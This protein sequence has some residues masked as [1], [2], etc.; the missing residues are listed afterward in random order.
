MSWLAW[1]CAAIS[2]CFGESAGCF[3]PAT[4]VTMADGSLREIGNVKIGEWVTSWDEDKQVSVAAKVMNIKRTQRLDLMQVKCANQS[5]IIV[6]TRDH[7][8]W[9]VKQGGLISANPSL[10]QVNY[11]L[12]AK[13]FLDHEL[14]QSID[15]SAVKCEVLS[16][17]NSETLREVLTLQL[18][19]H[20]W[21]FVEGVRVHNKGGGG[22]FVLNT[23][24]TMADESL[25]SIGEVQVGDSVMSWDEIKQVATPAKVLKIKRAKRSD[26][27]KVKLTGTN[28]VITA[29]RDHPFWS[30]KQQSLVSAEPENTKWGYDLDAKKFL[31]SDVLQAANGSAVSCSII[32]QENSNELVD[33]MTLFLEDHHWFFVEG[34]RVHN[35]G[36]GSSC[37]VPS[38]LI[39]MADEKTF[40][41]I[42]D[43]RI[44][45]SVLSWDERKN[46]R[47]VAKVMNVRRGQ[48]SEMLHV[49]LKSGKKIVSTVDHPYWSMKQKS[50]V[51]ADPRAT[52]DKYGLLASRFHV[53]GEILQD[54]NATGVECTASHVTSE[55]LLAVITLE[56]QDHHWFFAEGVRVHNKGGTYSGGT[57]SGSYSTRSSGGFRGTTSGVY[58]STYT[59]FYPIY[60]SRSPY[61]LRYPS[62][63]QCATSDPGDVECGC[64][65]TTNDATNFKLY[66]PKEGLRGGCWLQGQS[67][68]CVPTYPQMSVNDSRYLLATAICKQ[69][70]LDCKNVSDCAD[71]MLVNN[72]SAGVLYWTNFSSFPENSTD[73]F[74]AL[75]QCMTA[76]INFCK[77]EWEV[78]EQGKSA[79][80]YAGV[81]LGS[82]FGFLALCLGSMYVYG[83][84]VKKQREKSHW[85]AKRDPLI[86]SCKH[87]FEAVPCRELA[88]RTGNNAYNEGFICD[89]CKGGFAVNIKPTHCFDCRLDFCDGCLLKLGGGAQE[90]PQYNE[91]RSAACLEN[92]S[93]AASVMETRSADMGPAYSTGYTCDACHGIFPF[94]ATFERCSLCSLDFCPSCSI[95]RVKTEPAPWN[96]SAP[97][98]TEE[99]WPD[100]YKPE[101]VSDAPPQAY[102]EVAPP[103]QSN[104][105]NSL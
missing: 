98:A 102:E 62:Q 51:S 76:N 80:F 39:T 19:E 95:R 32:S 6:S 3:L 12:E 83:K 13:I 7:P 50:L 90:L 33:V 61:C 100:T 94:D 44:G 30:F 96:A 97:P 9:S 49:T 58:Y 72:Y 26:L 42:G 77:C 101:A 92:L 11:G 103:N 104:G 28:D 25:L 24:V 91:P 20:H 5:D 2:L 41:P 56:L 45:D 82:I 60:Y 23:K 4:K 8:Y 64:T 10:T 59:P 34:V 70:I 73:E 22:C 53:E 87:V 40:K 67:T 55:N 85:F 105:Y 47:T 84:C 88:T 86:D 52:Q 14:L 18:E 79:G 29:T 81:V 57:S 93:H 21:F 35:K 31:Q 99:P 71:E 89:V 43:V 63:P 78:C 48:R 54:A 37:F 1:I 46:I 75:S 27:L 15:G 36:G 65:G 66:C 38:T 16:R 68:T 74:L 17:A 69:A